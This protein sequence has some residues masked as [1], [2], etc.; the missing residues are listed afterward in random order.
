MY[1]GNYTRTVYLAQTHDERL[2]KKALP[3]S[4]K[5]GLDHE[6]RFTGLGGME[7]SLRRVS[8]PI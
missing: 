3:A 5:L 1:C 2:A 6:Y 8:G 7:C 4:H